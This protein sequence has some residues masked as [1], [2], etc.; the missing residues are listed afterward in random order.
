[1]SLLAYLSVCFSIV[2]PATG[3]LA[4]PAGVSE[5]VA[6]PK[7]DLATAT[8]FSSCTYS[9]ARFRCKLEARRTLDRFDVLAAALPASLLSDARCC[10]AY[11]TVPVV[12]A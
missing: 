8:T 9:R 1:M 12:D 7:P 5:A 3:T 10:E 4:P 11:A 6:E 2:G